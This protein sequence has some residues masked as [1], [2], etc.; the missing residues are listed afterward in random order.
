MGTPRHGVTHD[1]ENRDALARSWEPHSLGGAGAA[2]AACAPWPTPLLGPRVRWEGEARLLKMEGK[3]LAFRARAGTRMQ[4]GEEGD[5]PLVGT[6]PL[7][8]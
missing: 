6:F 2:V 7:P 4:L 5:L 1:S 8:R 3:P